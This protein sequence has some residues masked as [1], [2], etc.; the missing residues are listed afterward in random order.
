[1]E[2][3]KGEISNRRY[4]LVNVL[5]AL[6]I[7]ASTV[8]WIGGEYGFARSKSGFASIFAL[9]LLLYLL[10]RK[11]YL[12]PLKK[13]KNG[14]GIK[15]DNP[16][17]LL[18]LVVE[19]YKGLQENISR[20][21]SFI[22]AIEKGNL[23]ETYQVAE[24][25]TLG[26]SILSMR[27]YLKEIS[28]QEKQR[29]WSSEGL[30]RF[31]ELLRAHDAD[32][33]GLCE[34][35]LSHLVKYI[36][37]NQ[38]ALFVLQ[39]KDSEEAYM[40]MVACYAYGRKKFLN[41]KI[42]KGEGLVGQAWIENARVFLTDVP[43]D[44]VVITSGLGQATPSCVVIVPLKVN[45]EV[46]GVL[47]LASFT[48]IPEYQLQ[49]IEKLAENLASTI[50]MVQVN[51]RTRQLLEESQAL[52][53][54]M[55]AQE[56]EMRQNMEELQATQEELQRKE[57]ELDRKLQAAL[58]E[59][60]L[61]Q[62]NQ[63]MNEI[64]LQ[65]T[66]RIDSAKSDLKFLSNVPP[67]QGM[68]RALAQDGFDH[69]SNSS[70]EDWVERMDVIFRNFLINKELFQAITF[71]DE[72]GSI[73]Y[74][75]SYKGKVLE[76]NIEGLAAYQQEE[77]FVQASSLQKGEVYVG[78]VKSL[79]AG[80]QIMEFS[81]PIFDKKGK[82]KGA[83]LVHLFADTIIEGIRAKEDAEHKYSLFSSEG[84]CIFGHAPAGAGQGQTKAVVINQ[85]QNLQ[86]TIMHL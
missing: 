49:F 70:Y 32:I 55:R 19:K 68:I 31:N 61:G 30:T 12:I 6:I 42:L 8:F 67:V 63:Q 79:T 71:A 9:T 7:L 21:T 35:M 72:K 38:G 18:P 48:V 25:D 76:K 44:Y 16:Q 29:I 36:D 59:V 26:T 73:L 13:L 58:K 65:I 2:N 39:D 47:E 33:R 50:S 11:H 46:Y 75:L 28:A 82:F 37:A 56:E 5:F 43:R 1:M 64:A 69:E 62:I 40:E 74:A 86:L 78:H 57:G 23:E 84:I 60:E 34:N 17:E 27:E 24:E 14:F 51:E 54:Q 66:H 20:A 80:L 41:K 52:T 15:H 3:T 81:V 45:D 4:Y 53:E 83:I 10:F 77:I 85:K 22:R